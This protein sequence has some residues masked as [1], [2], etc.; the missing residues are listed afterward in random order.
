[1]NLDRFLFS[2]FLLQPRTQSKLCSVEQG[3]ICLGLLSPDLY[4]LNFLSFRLEWIRDDELYFSRERALNSR[5]WEGIF[6][7]IDQ[8]LEVGKT[9]FHFSIN[10]RARWHDRPLAAPNLGGISVGVLKDISKILIGERESI[11]CILRKGNK[12]YILLKHKVVSVSHLV[13]ERLQP[14]ARVCFIHASVV[15]AQRGR[16]G[17]P[18]CELV[19]AK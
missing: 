8:Q 3:F 16:Y 10:W 19:F 1:M 15:D 18:R 4:G 13:G 7:A 6:R 2:L 17:Q 5:A 11:N 9:L 14:L 12:V